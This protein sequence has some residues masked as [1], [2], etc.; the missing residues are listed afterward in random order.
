VSCP[1]GETGEFLQALDSK[2]QMSDSHKETLHSPHR[3]QTAE[4]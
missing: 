2:Q 3:Q 1:V 4:G